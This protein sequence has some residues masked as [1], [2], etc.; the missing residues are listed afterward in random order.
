MSKNIKIIV[1]LVLA[2]IMA[3]LVYLFVFGPAN[4]NDKVSNN[5]QI[6]TVSKIK[7]SLGFDYSSSR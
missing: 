3:A 1:L 7:R 5:A 4:G 2:A 6:S